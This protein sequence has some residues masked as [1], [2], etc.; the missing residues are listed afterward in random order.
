MI[1][2]PLALLDVFLIELEQFEDERGF[3]ARSW[4]E[5]E[6]AEHGLVHSFRQCNISFNKTK[7]TLRGMHFQNAPKAE[8]KIVRCSR[9]ALYDVVI[10]LRPESK[11]YCN[12]IGIELSEHN[13]NALYIPE[14][15]AHG[16]QSLKDETEV[17]YQMSE[18][19]D[20]GASNGVRWNDPTF[21][22]D[23]PIQ[24]PIMSRR[25]REF[26]DFSI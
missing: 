25:D 22:I 20:P 15:F 17:H 6:F 5:Q 1:F 23:W 10:D 7:G 8:T 14:G 26:A 16:F 13:R 4:C 12:W 2:K 18:L 21:N 9:G 3:F 19:Y 11:T 24:D